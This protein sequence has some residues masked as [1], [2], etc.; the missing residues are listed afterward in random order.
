MKKYW[1]INEMN[2][3]FLVCNVID[4]MIRLMGEIDEVVRYLN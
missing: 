1:R 2:N 4:K 3:I